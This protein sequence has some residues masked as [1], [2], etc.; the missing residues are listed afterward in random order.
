MCEFYSPAKN[1]AKD[2]EDWTRPERLLWKGHD[3]H[4]K[5]AAR[6]VRDHHAHRSTELKRWKKLNKKHRFV[7]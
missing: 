6:R 3:Q 1:F 5:D 7:V 4:A 2:D